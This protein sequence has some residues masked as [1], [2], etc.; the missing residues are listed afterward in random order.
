MLNGCNDATAK[1]GTEF[2]AV[3][4]H[5]SMQQNNDCVKRMTLRYSVSVIYTRNVRKHGTN[6]LYTFRRDTHR[7]DAAQFKKCRLFSLSTNATKVK[8]CNREQTHRVYNAFIHSHTETDES[9]FLCE[10]RGMRDFWSSRRCECAEKTRMPLQIN[11]CKNRC[12]NNDRSDLGLA[13][14]KRSICMYSFFATS[15]QHVEQSEERPFAKPSFT[16]SSQRSNCIC[17]TASVSTSSMRLSRH[18]RRRVAFATGTRLLRR[19][20][21]VGGYK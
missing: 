5:K 16:T 8:N 4:A 20:H 3:F 13:V 2:N 6:K 12:Q 9:L 21:C 11:A 14:F 15:E 19:G 17:K 18:C 10:S 7:N 1:R